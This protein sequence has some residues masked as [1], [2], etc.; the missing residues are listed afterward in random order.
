MNINQSLLSYNTNLEFSNDS[1]AI[2]PWMIFIVQ[3]GAVF[4]FSEEYLPSSRVYFSIFRHII[5]STFISGPAVI[6]FIV[7]LHFVRSEYLC[8]WILDYVLHARCFHQE[9]LEQ[10][11]KLAIVRENQLYLH[12][13][14]DH[15]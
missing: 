4:S 15:P 2:H 13:M 6:L 8:I 14:T 5:N 9:F 10:K 3:V 11:T 1:V 12:L 7:L